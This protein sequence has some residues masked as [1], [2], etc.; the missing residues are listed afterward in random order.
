MIIAPLFRARLPIVTDH[1]RCISTPGR[2]VDVLVTQRGVAVNPRRA[3]AC[4]QRLARR[5]RE[6]CGYS[7]TRSEIAEADHRQAWYAA[8]RRDARW[9]D[10]IYRD[11]TQID[12][13]HERLSR[14]C[15]VESRRDQPC[16]NIQASEVTKAVRRLCIDANCHLPADV[17][18][19]HRRMPRAGS[20]GRAR[21][22]Y[23]ISIIEN[24][25]IAR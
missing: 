24:Y 10:V 23:W 15:K 22:A 12:E 14:I 20:R 21:R 19:A 16:E 5:G 8:A 6:R 11:G 1:V 9:A 18:S 13:I 3:G 25:E 2:D 7:R 4:R 17:Q